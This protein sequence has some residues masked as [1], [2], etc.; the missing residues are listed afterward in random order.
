MSHVR[1]RGFTLIELLVVIAIIAVLIALLFPAVQSAREAA[2]RSQCVN[3]LKQIGLALHS[4][5]D[6]VNSFPMGVGS[7]M[8]AAN[9]YQAKQCWSIHSAILPRLSETPM[10]NAINFNWGVMLRPA[11]LSR[12]ISTVQKSQLKEFLCPSDPNA[13][14]MLAGGAELAQCERTTI[15]DASGPRPTCFGSLST[16]TA[17][18]VEHPDHGTVYLAAVEVAEQRPRRDIEYHRL[19]RIDRGVIAEDPSGG[20]WSE[21]DSVKLPTTAI[22]YDA[23]TNP[24][25]VM[26]GPPGLQRRLEMR[27]RSRSTRSAATR[28]SR[29]HGH[30]PLQHHSRPPTPRTTSEPSAAPR[31]GVP[32]P[33]SAIPTATTPE[34]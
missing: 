1:R 22:L 12:P 10:F 29:G 9:T 2:R 17:G 4:Y 14:Q 32:W 28:R 30:D 7:G 16:S 23:S 15:S 20:N 26:A 13:A 3:N 31:A 19:R 11:S 21:M 5:H 34:A 24:T 25:G 33:T 18:P 8:S 6:Q 27:A